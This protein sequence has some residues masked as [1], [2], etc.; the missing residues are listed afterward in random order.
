MNQ[1]VAAAQRS[2]PTHRLDL[3]DQ[4]LKAD[5]FVAIQHAFELERED[6]VQVTV[7]PGRKGA[8]GLR[9]RH[10]KMSVE[11]GDVVLPQKEVGRLRALDLAQSQR[12]RQASLPG[13]EV[14]FTTAARLRRAAGIICTPNWL[15]ARP[16]AS[17][18]ADRPCRPP[19]G[20]AKN[21]SRGHCTEHR[22]PLCLQSLR[23]RRFLRHQLRVIDLAGGVVQNH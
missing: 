11:L 1:D 3:Q 4:I 16:L 19:S 9:R 14:A 6:Q 5:R 10:S 2:S 22:K 20:S 15:S 17:A 23:F 21:D 18:D 13:A 7:R 8:A 12:L